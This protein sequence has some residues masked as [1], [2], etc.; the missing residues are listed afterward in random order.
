FSEVNQLMGDDQWADFLDS[1]GKLHLNGKQALS[2]ARIRYVGNSD[3]E[4]TSRQRE[5]FEKII[6][7]AINPVAIGRIA[8]SVIPKVNTNMSTFGMYLLSLKLPFAISYDIKQ[9]QIPA[10]NTFYPEDV[11]LYDGELQSVLQVDFNANY[12]VLEEEIF[13][14]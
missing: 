14:H 9:L 2:F 6:P 7:K 4:R 8:K 12:N 10:E 1:G 13:S 11:W 5:V 3:F